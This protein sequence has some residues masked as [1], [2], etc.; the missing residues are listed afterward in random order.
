[1]TV[2]VGEFTTA[3]A[4][5]RVRFIPFV[6]KPSFMDVGLLYRKGEAV[7]N[8][9]KLLASSVAFKEAHHTVG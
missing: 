4:G 7:D 6:S 2:V 3:V 1:L 8:V 9:M 5:D